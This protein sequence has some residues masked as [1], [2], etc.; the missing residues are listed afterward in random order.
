[1]QPVRHSILV[2]NTIGAEGLAGKPGREIL[3]DDEPANFAAA[4]LRLLGDS[5]ARDSIAQAAWSM[6][7]SQFRWLHVAREFTPLLE[8]GRIS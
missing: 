4:C 7:D 2:P 1:M 3:I 8:E 6:V 5:A